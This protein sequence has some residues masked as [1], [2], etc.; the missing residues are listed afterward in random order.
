MHLGAVS[1]GELLSETMTVI[2][3]LPAG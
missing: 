2:D 1:G 3:A